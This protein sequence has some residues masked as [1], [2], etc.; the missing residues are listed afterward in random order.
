MDVSEWLV[1]AEDVADRSKGCCLLV[2]ERLERGYGLDGGILVS[3]G[4]VEDMSGVGGCRGMFVAA[5]T[6]FRTV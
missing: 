3:D 1:V 4:H 2:G 5:S 6:V